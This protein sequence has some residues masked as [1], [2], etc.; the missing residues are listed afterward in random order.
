[1]DQSIGRCSFNFRFCTLVLSI[2][3]RWLSHPPTICGYDAGLPNLAILF[4]NVPAYQLTISNLRIRTPLRGRL[5]EI[6]YCILY[7]AYG[8]IVSPLIHIILFV[9]R[10]E[11]S[12]HI[13]LRTWILRYCILVGRMLVFTHCFFFRLCLFCSI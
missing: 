11:V 13:Q 9:Y 1:M 6:L 3:R 10:C 12:D 8:C 7:F 4:I 5:L 2:C